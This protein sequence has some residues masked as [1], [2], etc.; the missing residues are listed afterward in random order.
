MRGSLGGAALALGLVAAG[1]YAP[2][3][4]A[5][6]PDWMRSLVSVPTP[7]HDEKATAVV[8]HS[9]Y[10]VTVRSGTKLK[11]VERVAYRILRPGGEH[12]GLVRALTIFTP[13]R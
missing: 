6:P 5:V 2:S 11:R 1:M 13:G 4:A 9:E 3:A 12:F 8:M 10:L 7:E